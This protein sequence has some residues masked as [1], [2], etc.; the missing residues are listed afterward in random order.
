MFLFIDVGV[1]VSMM[2]FRA[3]RKN[4]CHMKTAHALS[5]SYPAHCQC[6]PF[7]NIRH[8]H[9]QDELQ[10]KYHVLFCASKMKMNF[11]SDMILESRRK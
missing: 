8:H 4:W 3:K 9:F 7:R 2:T 1:L 6:D 5:F 11:K 10:S